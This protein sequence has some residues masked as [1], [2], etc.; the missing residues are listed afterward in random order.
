M[1]VLRGWGGG[2]G[3]SL[4][5]SRRWGFWEDMLEDVPWAKLAMVLESRWNQVEALLPQVNISDLHF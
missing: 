2:Q 1:G 4:T 3:G 5:G